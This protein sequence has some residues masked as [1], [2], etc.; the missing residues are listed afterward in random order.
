MSF[1][2]SCTVSFNIVLHLSAVLLQTFLA[3]TIG[4]FLQVVVSTRCLC[5]QLLH[6]RVLNECLNLVF[7]DSPDANF[8]IDMKSLYDEIT[9]LLCVNPET[10]VCESRF[11]VCESRFDADSFSDSNMAWVIPESDQ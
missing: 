2:K 9:S 6:K 11:V 10:C 5:S 8:F 3:R 1:S 7:R 4:S